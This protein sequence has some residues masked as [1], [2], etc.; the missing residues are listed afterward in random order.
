MADEPDNSSPERSHAPRWDDIEP[1]APSEVSTLGD[2]ARLTPANI[3]EALECMD[4]GLDRFHDAN[5]NR[6]IFLGCYRVITQNVHD[7]I[8]QQRDFDNRIFFDP[9]WVA[10]LSGRFA[11]LYFRSLQQRAGDVDRTADASHDDGAGARAWRIA[12]EEARKG[13]LSVTQHVLLGINAHINYDLPLALYQNL[14]AHADQ[15]EPYAQLYRRKFDHDQVNN[16]LVRS[17]PEAQQVVGANYGGLLGCV[18]RAFFFLDDLLANLGLKHRGLAFARLNGRARHGAVVGEHP[19]LP[20]GKDLRPGR[21]HRDLV[22]VPAGLPAH[23]RH[24][25]R[26]RE[27]HRERLRQL[28]LAQMTRPL[29]PGDRLQRDGQRGASD[30]A[31]LQHLAAGEGTCGHLRH[32][33]GELLCLPN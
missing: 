29:G 12:H 25:R 21:G 5:D 23:P 4:T 7:A 3:D 2:L 14:V 1:L 19:R 28:A 24:R 26:D 9:A 11:T 30:E 15:D 22:E 18:S 8:E 31:Q 17:I 33:P 27:R 10:R 32:P 20:A 6:A 16:I 13:R